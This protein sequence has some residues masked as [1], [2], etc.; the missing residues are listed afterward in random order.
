MGLQW[1]QVFAPWDFDRLVKGE[2]IEENLRSYTVTLTCLK[3]GE[4]L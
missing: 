4:T 1:F 2:G 3:N